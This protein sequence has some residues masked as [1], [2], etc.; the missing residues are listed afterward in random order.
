MPGTIETRL[1]WTV[2]VETDKMNNSVAIWCSNIYVTLCIKQFN[3]A[4]NVFV[5]IAQ[6]K[7]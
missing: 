4:L 1:K 6:L 2:L 5:V 3:M 7:G